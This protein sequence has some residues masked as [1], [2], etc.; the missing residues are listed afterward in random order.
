MTINE[1]AILANL[2]LPDQGLT[3]E[4][5]LKAAT[6]AGFNPAFEKHDSDL[7]GKGQQGCIILLKENNAAIFIP[8]TAGNDPSYLIADQHGNFKETTAAALAPKTIGFHISLQPVADTQSRIS[9]TKSEISTNIPKHR[10]WFWSTMWDYRAL[11]LQL[12]PASLMVNLFA[13]VMPF[14]VMIIYDRVVPN[15]AVETLWVLAAGVGLV[16]M[17]DLAVRLVRG[18]LIERAGNEMDI[19]LAGKLYEQLMALSMRAVPA[20]MGNLASRIRSYE[21]LREFFVSATMLAI[22][23]MP[24][25]LL[26]IG[27]VFY[28]AGP[29]GWVLVL[30]TLIAISVSIWI[31]FPLYKSVRSSAEIGLERNAF[32]GESIANLEPIKVNNAE[33]YF[34]RRMNRLLQ[35]AT[36]NSAKSHWY[37]LM[38]NS[39]T[40]TI[41]NI[42]SVII[43]VTGVYQ[44]SAGSLTMGGLIAC[45]ML[46]SRCMAP[47]AMLSGLMTRFQQA[48][49]SLDSLNGVMS[50][51]R[52]ASSDRQY[53]HHENFKP[54]LTFSDVSVQYGE[55]ANPALRGITLQ[56]QEGEKIALLGRIGSGKSTLLQ[57]IAGL[58]PISGGS[59]LVDGFELNQY[60]PTALRTQ[61]GYVPQEAALF[62]GSIRDNVALGNSQ[63]TDT[64]ILRA[65]ELSGLGEFIKRHPQGL[66]SEVGERG[67]LLSG[68]QR[69]SITLARCIIQNNPLLLLDEPTANL[70]PQTE[71]A[72]VNTLKTHC[73][74]RTLIVATHKASV[75]E[76]V[77]RAIILDQGKIVS[78]GP[79]EQVLGQMRRSKSN[80]IP[81]RI[82][83]AKATASTSRKKPRTEGSAA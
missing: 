38:A 23:D 29:I 10:H 20:S 21:T 13:L 79:V 69:R 25:A 82:P 45:V 46:G 55:K 60:H 54:Q 12:L 64:E 4:L 6:R 71:L 50:L 72:F 31:Q 8:Q 76:L 7:P 61:I 83:P 70:D 47:M 18:T 68:G 51:E 42:T 17:F 66:L 24:F 26:M 2:P 73:E 43:V 32:I 67:A 81:T 36:A 16:F 5:L 59:I 78:D 49:Q 52:E 74:N 15:N 44:V 40:T 53:L 19:E 65:L 62:Y 3:P 33:G 28:L 9:D 63:L 80:E 35:D 34:Q 39:L 77:D 41:I 14:F 22:A 37:G 1:E 56:V 57:V 75:L 11:Y 30:A 27:A 58:Q 48:L